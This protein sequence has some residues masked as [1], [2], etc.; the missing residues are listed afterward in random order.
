MTVNYKG[1]DKKFNYRLAEIN[2]DED[3]EQALM[4]KIEQVMKIRG[5]YIDQVTKGYALCEVE[6]RDGYREFVKDYKEVR[7]SAKMWIRFGF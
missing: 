4:D 3:T 1:M 6:D 2:F 5:Y 7:K